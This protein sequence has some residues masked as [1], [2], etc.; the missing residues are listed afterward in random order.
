M[1]QERRRKREAASMVPATP[2]LGE[3]K[4]EQGGEKERGKGG[5]MGCSSLRKSWWWRGRGPSSNGLDYL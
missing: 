3:V 2:G 5:G 4:I 1:A